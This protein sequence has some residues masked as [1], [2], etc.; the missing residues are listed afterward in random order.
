[1]KSPAAPVRKTLRSTPKVPQ[2]TTPAPKHSNGPKTLLEVDPLPA[3][4]GPSLQAS[5]KPQCAATSYV[6]VFVLAESGPLGGPRLSRQDA[7]ERAGEPLE[8]GEALNCV[9]YE[10]EHWHGL[11]VRVTGQEG[12][13]HHDVIQLHDPFRAKTLPS[14]LKSI[15][16]RHG[17]GVAEL[18][19][20]PHSRL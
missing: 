20:I 3:N 11:H 1:M 14:I 17:I 13:E 19:R 10:K 8:G 18:F 16:R 4:T 9:D 2:L 6:R 5:T 15:A 7:W 12:G